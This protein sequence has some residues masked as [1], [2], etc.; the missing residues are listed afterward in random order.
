MSR[1][2]EYEKLKS[3]LVRLKH[4]YGV[5]FDDWILAPYCLN[6]KCPCFNTETVYGQTKEGNAFFI[7][8]LA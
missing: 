6:E 5:D 1:E 7:I 2:E 4:E 3:E 8:E